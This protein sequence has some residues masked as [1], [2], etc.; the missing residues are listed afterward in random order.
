MYVLSRQFTLMLMITNQERDS[1][2]CL[3]LN[4]CDGL[5]PMLKFNIDGL[6][7][8][9]AHLRALEKQLSWEFY[10]ARRTITLNDSTKT[11]GQVSHCYCTTDQQERNAVDVAM[12]TWVVSHGFIE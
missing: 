4:F 7:Y 2:E 6:R 11:L 10:E 12:V 3:I 1:H 9:Q 8:P 5:K